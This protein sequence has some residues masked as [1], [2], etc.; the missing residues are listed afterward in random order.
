MTV[1]E[2]RA[3]CASLQIRPWDD[4]AIADE[5]R[6]VTAALLAASPQV[7]PVAGAPGIWW[8]GASGFDASGGETVL[9]RTLHDIVRR[10]HPKARVAIADS[11]V[12]AWAA[13]WDMRRDARREAEHP[14]RRDPVIVIPGGCAAYLAQAPLGL[15]PMDDD[16]RESLDALGIRTAGRLAAL[17]AEDVERRWGSM[18]LRAWRLASGDDPRRPVL[19][20]LE[21]P[22]SV[23]AEL[24]PSVTGMEPIL[25]LV[26][27]ALDRLARELVADGRAA[28][29]VAITLTL[30][31][32]RGAIP[33]SGRAH[34]ITR[35]IRLP[36]PMARV[37]PLL[38]RCRALLERWELTAPVCALTVTIPASAPSTGEQGELL[39]PAWRDPAAADA[40]FARLRAELGPR[41]IVRPVARDEH[42]PEHAGDWVEVEA[43]DDASQART[44][45]QTRNGNRRQ[46][47]IRHTD[48]SVA[49]CATAPEG[50]DRD[51]VPSL[52][53]RRQ[54]GIPPDTAAPEPGRAVWSPSVA[55][56]PS[57]TPIPAVPPAFELTAA[58]RHLESPE[59][60][61]VECVGER[62]RA[63]WWR[64]RRL[65]VRNAIG[66][67]RL[68]GD[69]WKDPYVRDYWRCDHGES[70]ACLLIYRERNPATDTN[71][72]YAQGWYD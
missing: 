69:W 1:S 39:D 59:P 68:T 27:A 18:G 10:W 30:D 6:R 22:R 38:E 37:A 28:A 3:R 60:I 70:A 13:T 50:R 56:H 45:I 63:L 44:D 4:V 16:L 42:R 14:G 43:E 12:A 55:M 9:A 34:T 29:I 66:P 19:A 2:A 11:C 32:A 7:A 62:P 52:A 53:P 21:S 23:S 49:E 35:E 67:E 5:V 25:F 48:G 20:R 65:H 40:A 71:D 57:T 46:A 15:F 17:A 61:A 72:W 54:H 36:R 26:R 58:F 33:G 8:V 51:R 47:G 24:S 64:G 41:A 31:D